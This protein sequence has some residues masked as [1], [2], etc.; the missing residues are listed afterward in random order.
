MGG[1]RAQS[2]GHR[3]GLFA[4]AHAALQLSVVDL[5]EDSLETR[6]WGKARGD[7]IVAGDP[8]RRGKSATMGVKMGNFGDNLTMQ[9]RVS[10]SEEV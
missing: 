8:W 6:A 1:T 7:Q 3:Q 9:S 5:I 4:R 10:P 2:Q